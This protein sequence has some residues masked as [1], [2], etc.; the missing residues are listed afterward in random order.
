MAKFT[1]N[2]CT[3]KQMNESSRSKPV[4]RYFFPGFTCFSVPKV[5]P[6]LI[7]YGALCTRISASIGIG[8]V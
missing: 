7:F 6:F 2:T 4:M 3:Y 8:I 5:L 1:T